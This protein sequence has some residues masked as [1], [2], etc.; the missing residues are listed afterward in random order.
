[1]KTIDLEFDLEFDQLVQACRNIGFDLS[2]GL[3]A[4]LFYTGHGASAGQEH[5]DSCFSSIRKAGGAAVRLVGERGSADLRDR[6]LRLYRPPFRREH[7]HVFDSCND[8][9]VDQTVLRVRGWGKIGHLPDPEALQDA[10]GDLIAEA[11]TVFWEGE[12]SRMAPRG[13][14]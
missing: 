12:L 8:V 10:A 11:L 2:C 14:K 13:S 4:Q 7:G 1:L 9:V 6:A 5:D 3:C